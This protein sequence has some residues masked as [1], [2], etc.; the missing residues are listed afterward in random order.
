MRLESYL[1]HSWSVG[2]GW[3]LRLSIDATKHLPLEAE[4]QHLETKLHIL[5]TCKGNS[6][7]KTTGWQIFLSSCDLD[8]QPKLSPSC[9]QRLCIQGLNAE[10]IGWL[11]CMVERSRY[12][13]FVRC[14]K[15]SLSKAIDQVP[16]QLQGIRGF[17]RHFAFYTDLKNY[18]VK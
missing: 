18:S 9:G 6:S 11:S 1:N 3:R 13:S 4:C 15:L 17:S 10:V 12:P 14:Q 16:L 5:S 2:Q 7:T 8:P